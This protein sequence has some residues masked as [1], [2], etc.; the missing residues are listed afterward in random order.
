MKY[1]ASFDVKWNKS[2]TRPQAY[3][4]WRNH[5]SRTKCISQIPQGIYFVENSLTQIALGFFLAPP[6]G[7]EPT[8]PWLTVMCSTDWAK[9]EYLK[10]AQFWA[11]SFCVGYDLSFRTV[12]SQVFSALQSLTSVFGMGT[13]G[14]FA[15]KKPTW[16]QRWPIF[17]SR[18]QL[19]IF[20][21]AKL[22]FRVRNGN[23]WTLCVKNTDSLLAF[24][25]R[26]CLATWAG[27]PSGI[28]TRDP[29]QLS[30][31]ASLRVSSHFLEMLHYF[32]WC[33]FRDL[34]PGPTD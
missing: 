18:L 20:G 17:P 14:P 27:A 10:V 1:L 9:E 2:S 19:S 29:M 6:V 15:L 12:S 30:P 24:T 13:G 22:N 25:N 34:N 31:Q 21:T 26:F 7:L 8:T 16:C 5:I 3:F 32:G 23:G 28:W 11:T 4:T 33:T